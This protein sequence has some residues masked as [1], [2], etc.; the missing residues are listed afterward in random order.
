[1]EDESGLKNT[2]AD[3]F[4]EHQCDYTVEEYIDFPNYRLVVRRYNEKYPLPTHEG[5]QPVV[6]DSS[7]KAELKRMEMDGLVIIDKQN[8]VK[9]AHT[10]SKCGPDYDEGANFISESIVLTTKGKSGWRYFVHKATENPITTVL[11]SVA[12][13]ISIIALFL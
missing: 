2:Y 12:I 13:V 4:G 11:S 7:I 6:L 3:Y 1:M 8:A 5:Q 9:Y 10:D